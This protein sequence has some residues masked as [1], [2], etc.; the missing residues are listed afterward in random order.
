MYFLYKGTQASY[1]RDGASFRST[2][3]SCTVPHWENIWYA[4]FWGTVSYY[5][6]ILGYR[7]INQILH[8]QFMIIWYGQTPLRQPTLWLSKFYMEINF[9]INLQKALFFFHI[10]V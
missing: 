1:R 3:T 10:H 7:R 2:K 4:G 9:S 6:H 8:A 5:G